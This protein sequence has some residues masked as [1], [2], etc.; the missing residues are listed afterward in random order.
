MG[1][2]KITAESCTNSNYNGNVLNLQIPIKAVYG[3]TPSTPVG[4]PS[5]TVNTSPT[6]RYE[7]DLITYRT[8]G[9][10]DA[11]PFYVTTYQWEVPSGWTITNQNYSASNVK[12]Y[13]D[14]RPDNCTGGTIRVRAKNPC[15]EYYSNWSPVITVARTIPTP[16]DISGPDFVVCTNTTP[17]QFSVT[18]VTGATS[19]VWTKPS[20]WSGTSTTNSITLTP[21]GTTG[22]NVT[23]KAEGCNLQSTTASV[24]PIS[25]QF[26]N[27]SNPPTIT[28]PSVIPCTGAT[29]TLNNLPAGATA[30]WLASPGYFYSNSG[31]GTSASLTPYDLSSGGPG[32]VTFTIHTACDD[33]QVQSNNFSVQ[34]LLPSAIYFTNSENEGMYFCSSSY[35]N[36]FEIESG[37]SGT[38]YEARLL[39]ITGQTVLYTSSVTNYQA[40]TPNLWDY[41]PSSD[42]YYVFEV[43]GTN[44]CGSTDW[45]GTEVEYVNCSSLFTV[46]PNPADNYV[47]I[48]MYADKMTE[49]EIETKTEAYQITIVDDTGTEVLK[50]SSK[51]KK[52]LVDT[53]HLKNGRYILRIQYGGEITLQRII[54]DR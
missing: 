43:R 12:A 42:G 53:S 18:A 28:G 17:V 22:G 24:K 20:G 30:T 46:Y 1:T 14:V 21:S 50:A 15:G 32:T 49:T 10:S 48:E 3:Q 39:D 47:N 8:R 54:I 9:S 40:G 19:Y 45:V 41:Y 11:N 23:V 29:F 25:L 7:V 5:V 16:G 44:E 31:S 33:F 4:E 27:P 13:I 36:Y 51:N 35:G 34:G 26:F 37:A 2:I 6:L 38:S 52:Q